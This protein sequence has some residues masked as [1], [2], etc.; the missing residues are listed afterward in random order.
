MHYLRPLSTLP[1]TFVLLKG[2]S[3]Y[4]LL[5]GCEASSSGIA[6]QVSVGVTAFAI[7]LL[8]HLWT[9]ARSA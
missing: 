9:S 4:H 2:A 6:H 8:P 1:S 5:L 7:T 3:H